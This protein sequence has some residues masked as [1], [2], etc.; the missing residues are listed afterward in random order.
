MLHVL[1]VRTG[2]V[3]LEEPARLSTKDG[4]SQQTPPLCADQETCQVAETLTCSQ[5]L[6]FSPASLAP[7]LLTQEGP[8]VEDGHLRTSFLPVPL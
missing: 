1:G 7:G 3:P 5:P 4:E 2:E 8:L 6:D